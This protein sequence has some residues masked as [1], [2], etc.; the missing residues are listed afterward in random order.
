MSDTVPKEESVDYVWKAD[1]FV[2]GISG[3]NT[4]NITWKRIVG[5][6]IN[7]QRDNRWEPQPNNVILDV[8]TLMPISQV[9]REPPPIPQNNPSR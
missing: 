9:P 1:E 4:I 7:T 2:Q 3:D 6:R 5:Q 8:M